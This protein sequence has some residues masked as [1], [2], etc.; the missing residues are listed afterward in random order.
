SRSMQASELRIY[1][2]DDRTGK[3]PVTGVVSP[4][5]RQEFLFDVHPIPLPLLDQTHIHKRP[6]LGAL[7]GVGGVGLKWF[8]GMSAGCVA[9]TV[10]DAVSSIVV[11]D[12]GL[13]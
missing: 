11:L 12:P 4:F 10:T 6:A 8:C 9:G 13:S 7:F 5:G 1:P 2:L 3:R